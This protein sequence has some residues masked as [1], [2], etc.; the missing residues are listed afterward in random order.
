M[1]YH[2]KNTVLF[3]YKNLKIENFIGIIELHEIHILFQ[4]FAFISK[5]TGSKFKILFC[6]FLEKKNVLLI[7]YCFTVNKNYFLALENTDKSNWKIK[8][9]DN[10]S[11]L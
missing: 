5:S 3:S 8:R 2:L 9:T 7:F 6:Y 4:T 11:Q 1:S 10:S